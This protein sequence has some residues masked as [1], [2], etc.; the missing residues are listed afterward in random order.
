M[1]GLFY[2]QE[3][4]PYFMFC[5]WASK[6]S[7]RPCLRSKSLVRLYDDFRDFKE[8]VIEDAP[9]LEELVGID[10]WNGSAFLKILFAPKLQ[11]LGCLGMSA[12]PLVLHDTVLMYS[13]CPDLF[14][15]LEFNTVTKEKES[16][17]AT[18]LL[19]SFKSARL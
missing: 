4:G 3:M 12:G 18:A 13:L 9:N 6:S 5:T 1:C 19:P 16:E 8:L 14:D 15:V 10:L 11:V 17:E 2:Y 7:G